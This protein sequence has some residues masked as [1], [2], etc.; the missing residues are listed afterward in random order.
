[1]NG[2]NFIDPMGE[3]ITY[4][5]K[6]DEKKYQKLKDIIEQR[7]KTM[8]PII[9]M[10]LMHMLN[11]IEGSDI[12]F[13][14]VQKRIFNELSDTNRTG[15]MLG[16]EEV[17]N[18]FGK[19]ITVNTYRRGNETYSILSK[20]L[21]ELAHAYQFLQGKVG[22]NKVGNNWQPM[23]Y[24]YDMM[25]EAEALQIQYLVANKRDLAASGGLLRKI[26]KEKDLKTIKRLLD[27]LYGNLINSGRLKP[28]ENPPTPGAKPI[29]EGKRHLV[30]ADRF[31]YICSEI[32]KEGEE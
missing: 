7:Y 8:Y 9:Y 1:M 32:I 27:K 15:G 29:D 21:H 28:K 10:G 6:T 13:H 18:K 14:I 23:R 5:T 20:M 16:V 26:I 30:N 19:R 12:E 4:G 11:E 31:F 3:K 25:D 22:F 24:S 17:N 2:V